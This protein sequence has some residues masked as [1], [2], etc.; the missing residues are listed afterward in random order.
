[1][2]EVGGEPGRSSTDHA[3][4]EFHQANQRKQQ[5]WP[6]TLNASS[7]HDTKRSEDVRARID[8]LSE[9]APAWSRTLRKVSRLAAALKVEAEELAP[10]TNEELLI[11]QTLL[12]MWPLDKKEEPLVP[13]RLAAYL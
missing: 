8:V 5:L 6:H 1:M 9:I 4:E 3:L 11:Y 2:N 7:T 13:E 12:G 10:D